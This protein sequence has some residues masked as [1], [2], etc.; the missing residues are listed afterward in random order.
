MDFINGPLKEEVYVSQPDGFIDPDHPEKVYRLKK[1]LYGLKQTPK[2]WYDE[3]LTFMISKGFTKGLKIHQSSRGIFI[4]QVKYAFRNTQKHGM[5]ICDST[6]ILI[7]TKPKLDANFSG[8]PVDQTRYQSM[9]G[10]L[11]YLTSSR[12]DLV[13]VVCY[14]ARYQS[15]PMEKH[16][17]EVKRIFW[18][19]KGTIN[20]G[21]GYSKDSGFELTAFLDADHAGC[22]DTRKSTSGGIQFLGDKLVNWMSKKQDY[23]LMSTT[24]VEYTI[25]LGLPEDIYA[26]VDSCETAQEI[27][28]RVQQMM[29]GS[30]IRIQDKK[31]KLF[32]EWERFTFNEGE[33]IESYYHRF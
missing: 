12:P 22:R 33:S 1:A 17:K 8:T 13:Q 26:A 20:M 27:W 18:Y 4:N 25:L 3:L 29:K 16:L 23:T 31:A 24:E 32:N 6:G 21:L 9:I 30:N 14:C 28:L 11:M 10:S 2:S 5:D 7:A 19:L 15:R